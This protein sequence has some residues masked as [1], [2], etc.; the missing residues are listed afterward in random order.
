M[1]NKEKRRYTKYPSA[2]LLTRSEA[3]KMVGVHPATVG[4]LERRGL[5]STA[6]RLGTGVLRYERTEILRYLAASKDP[7]SS[8]AAVEEVEWENAVKERR[9]DAFRQRKQGRCDTPPE[10]L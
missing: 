7:R 8:K 6:I 2:E 3:A 4:R 10:S 5:F 9:L 1:Q